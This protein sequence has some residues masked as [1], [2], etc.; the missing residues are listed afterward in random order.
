MISGVYRRFRHASG[1][2]ISLC[3][4]LICA[5]AAQDLSPA[6]IR[7]ARTKAH[8]KEELAKLPNYTCLETVARFHRG[9]SAKA[10][11][12]PLDRVSLEIVSV[13]GRE[14]YGA[15]GDRSLS[16]DDPSSF[17]ASGMMGNGFFAI[18]VQNLF[19]NEAGLLQPR[20]IET[21]DGRAAAKVDFRLPPIAHVTVP[22]GSGMVAEQGS[23]WT[24]PVSM[25]LLRLD[26]E[27]IDIPPLLP[28]ASMEYSVQYARTRVGEHDTV[29]PQQATLLMRLV[30]NGDDFDRFDFTHCRVFQS[31]SAVHFDTGDS[32]AGEPPPAG[33]VHTAS[34]PAA[35][36]TIPA[37]LAVSIELTTP[38]TDR[39]PVGEIVEG[40]VVGAVRHK[41]RIAIE[42]GALVRGRLRRNEWYTA[43]G[44]FIVGL[45][46]TEIRVHGQPV[47]FY[48]D[49]LS[50]EKRKGVEAELHE[51]VAVS[52]QP[53]G[54]GWVSLP[55]VPGVAQFFVEG[56]SYSLGAGFRTTWRTR[57][58]LNGVR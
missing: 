17:T 10:K 26:G 1:Q 36:D 19:V 48:A 2:A 28:M 23:F 50:L 46:F 29:L 44:R 20:G 24:D 21:I 51:A 18:T 5:A 37:L 52:T 43:R 13:D 54:E 11:F 41:G 33:P 8:M 47:P 7:L 53:V 40:R 31:E 27:A 35:H 58:P 56:K 3:C 4:A 14:W 30:G 32:A 57:G 34:P 6:V 39:D 15:P 55:E 12:E 9:P 38:I 49:L 25:D 42:N 22:N 16:V 45:E